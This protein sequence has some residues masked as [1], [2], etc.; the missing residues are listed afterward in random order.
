MTTQPIHRLV[1]A[2]AADRSTVDRRFASRG[3]KEE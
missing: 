2:V 1:A 3:L